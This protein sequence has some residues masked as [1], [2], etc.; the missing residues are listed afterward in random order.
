M[1]SRLPHTMKDVARLA[2]V[3]VSTVSAVINGTSKVT[4]ERTRK[5]RDAMEALDYHPDQVARSLKTGSTNVIGMVIPDVTNQ[6]YS[7]VVLG[8]EAAARLA[9]Y[10]VILCNSNEDPDQEQRS[11]SALRARRVDGVLISCCNTSRSYDRL[12]RGN[13]P[14]VFFDRIPASVESGLCT[15]NQAA[16]YRGTRHLIELGHR[17]IAIIA[18]NVGL[19][20]HAGRLEGFRT[21]MQEV[22]LPVR[23]EYLRT[24]AHCVEVGHSF[25]KELLQLPVPPTAIFATNNKLLLGLVSAMNEMGVKCPS[26]VSVVGFDDYAWTQNFYPKLTTVAQ[27]THE[28]GRKAMEML[29]EELRDNGSADATARRPMVVL[30]SELRIRQSTAAPN[31]GIH[32]E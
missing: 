2:G 21:A 15:D 29:L 20:P 3:S 11:L 5:I 30:E 9:N 4:A 32:R 23:K 1:R 22:G 26:E 18:G 6:F 17:A 31:G 28:L 12:Q 19:S 16:A 25:G 14:V 27:P 13:W 24:G 10:S 8:V 7:E